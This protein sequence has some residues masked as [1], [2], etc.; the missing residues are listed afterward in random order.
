M[1]AGVAQTG[2]LFTLA[3]AR[4]DGGRLRPRAGRLLDGA[5]FLEAGKGAAKAAVLVGLGALTLLP[6]V[7]PWR[8]WPGPRRGGCCRRPGCWRRRWAGAWSRPA[9]CSGPWTWSGSATGTAARCA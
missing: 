8:G 4:P 2:G 3:P 1:V 6:L 7:R 5:T 9:W